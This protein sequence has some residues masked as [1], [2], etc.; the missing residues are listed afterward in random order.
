MAHVTNGGV[1]HV[2]VFV[3][4][5]WL[6]S[7]LLRLTRSR[8]FIRKKVASKWFLVILQRTEMASKHVAREVYGRL[9][10]N[11][12]STD[13]GQSIVKRYQESDYQCVGF[14]MEQVA[15]HVLEHHVLTKWYALSCEAQQTMRR[16]P[17]D[18]ILRARQAA[19][20][21]VFVREKKVALLAQLAKRQFS[22][23]YP[24]LLADLLHAWQ[25][26]SSDHVELV[27]LIL[28][29]VSEDCVSSSFNTSIPPT[30]RKE[31]VQGLNV[32]LPQLVPVV[33]HELDGFLYLVNFRKA[34][35]SHVFDHL[36]ITHVVNMGA[37]TDHRN[38]FDHVEYLDVAIKDNVDV[39]ITQEFGLTIESIEKA[40]DVGG[41]VLLYCVQG[42]SRSSTICICLGTLQDFYDG[43]FQTEII[44]IKII[45]LPW[46]FSRRFQSLIPTMIIHT[47][48]TNNNYD[49]DTDIVDDFAHL[50]QPLEV[51]ARTLHRKHVDV[52]LTTRIPAT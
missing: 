30:R 10:W 29:L 14:D 16:E 50:M 26:G 5:L 39:D 19:D 38:K 7:Y 40:T 15:L 1:V 13:G 27:L 2:R 36:H 49:D 21:P 18:L 47:D 41:R 17:L 43:I 32:C 20:E 51:T 3:R 23:R 11:L 37:I 8:K 9:A 42:V 34:N 28:R 44:M 52:L 46:G 12:N 45:P 33:Y 31:I 48:D 4:F 6:R 22:Q 24:D 25:S 35:S